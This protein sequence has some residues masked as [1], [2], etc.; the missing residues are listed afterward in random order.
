MTRPRVSYWN[1]DLTSIGVM[2]PSKF[3][4]RSENFTG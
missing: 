3:R 2:T 4:E 1:V